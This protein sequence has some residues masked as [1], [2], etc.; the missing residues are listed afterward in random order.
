MGRH[1]TQTCTLTPHARTRAGKLSKGD[2]IFNTKDQKKV[3]VPRLVRMHS[4]KMEDVD[5]VEAGE[6]CA[7]FGL[8]CASGDTFTSG[9]TSLS[10]ESMYV[11]ARGCG[12][13]KSVCG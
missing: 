4:D 3:K 10:M 2:F 8:D 6:I 13:G 11:A 7:L 9:G 1:C 12:G 5:S